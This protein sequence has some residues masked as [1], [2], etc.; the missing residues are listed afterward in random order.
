M[1][2]K[3]HNTVLDVE[4]ELKGLRQRSVV[5]GQLRTELEVR[6]GFAAGDDPDLIE[7]RR[8]HWE[9]PDRNVINQLALDLADLWLRTRERIKE[10][11]QRLCSGS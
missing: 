6:F 8:G 10:L 7:L 5:L 3:K 9:I 2:K 1:T 11:E 4:H